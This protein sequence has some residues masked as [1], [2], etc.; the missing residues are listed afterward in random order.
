M[1]AT[2][3]TITA[4]FT[5]A[6]NRQLPHGWDDDRVVSYIRDALYVELHRIANTHPTLFVIPPEII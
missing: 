1:S 2:M 6:D 5:V 4:T 3:R